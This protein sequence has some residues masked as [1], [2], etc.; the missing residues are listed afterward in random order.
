MSKLWTAILEEVQAMEAGPMH[1]LA[2]RYIRPNSQLV[3]VLIDLLSD[4]LQDQVFEV[5]WLRS[6]WRDIAHHESGLESILE[7]DLQN[8]FERDFACHSLTEALLLHRGFQALVAHRFAHC[9][10]KA[11]ERTTAKWLANRTAECWG[12]DIH[13]AAKI[14]AGLVMDHCM[15]IV[16]GETCEIGEHVFLF[17]NVTLGGTGRTTGDRHPKLGHHVVVG[18]GATILGNIKIGDHAVIAAGAMVLKAVPQAVLVAG[19]PARI[20]GRAKPVQ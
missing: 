8:Y 15:G 13:P 3:D 5:G 2:E 20:K 17:H 9:L 19:I 14:G 6:Q 4:K 10:W 16:I 12:V 1:I 18:T 7:I 11:G